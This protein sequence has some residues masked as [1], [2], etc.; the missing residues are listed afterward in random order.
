VQ[1]KKEK[2]VPAPKPQPAKK[3]D[4]YGNG[5][6][7]GKLQVKPEPS[8]DAISTKKESVKEEKK[9]TPWGFNGD[10]KPK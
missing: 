6:G 7:T 8:K 4:W 10:L 2:S 9:P 1:T 5:L 3:R